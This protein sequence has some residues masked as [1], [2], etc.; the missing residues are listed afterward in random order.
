MEMEQKNLYRLEIKH[1]GKKEEGRK[2]GEPS[3]A[4]G[5]EERNA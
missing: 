5:N 1:Q 3:G 4:A 2:E